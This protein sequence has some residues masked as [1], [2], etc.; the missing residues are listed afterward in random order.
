MYG[1]QPAVRTDPAA[2]S[3]TPVA[4]VLLVLSDPAGGAAGACSPL[5][6]V[7][8]VLSDPAS[9]TNSSGAVRCCSPVLC[10][11]KVLVSDR[12]PRVAATR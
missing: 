9:G 8:L 11:A 7:F 10:P 12:N 4:A 1:G 5:S 2:G 6:A 3:D